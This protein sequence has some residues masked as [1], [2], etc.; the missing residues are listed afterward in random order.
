MCR[1]RLAVGR[2]DATRVLGRCAGL[3]RVW[4]RLRFAATLEASEVTRRINHVSLGGARV[5]V[6]LIV[7]WTRLLE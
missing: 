3:P 2:P 4:R 7:N 5:Q 6:S 1:P